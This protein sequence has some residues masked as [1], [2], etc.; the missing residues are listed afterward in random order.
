MGAPGLFIKEVEVAKLLGHNVTW[1][2]ANANDLERQYGLPKIDPAIG[3]RHLEAIEI[4]ARQRNVK[5][6]IAR[7]ERLT[8][9]NQEKPNAF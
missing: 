2:H 4:W 3:L 7:S 9:T 8:E 5:T 6:N 1:L